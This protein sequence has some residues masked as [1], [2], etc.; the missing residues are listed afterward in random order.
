M[1]K[2]E[3]LLPGGRAEAGDAGAEGSSAQGGGGQA[4]VSPT[5]TL[6]AQAPGP[7]WK[8]CLGIFECS[9]LEGSV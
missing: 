4:A 8:V 2:Q 5:P 6:M 7:S 9:H 1:N 3:E